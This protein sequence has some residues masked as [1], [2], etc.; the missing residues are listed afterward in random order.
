M[1]DAAIKALL[2]EE[3]VRLRKAEGAEMSK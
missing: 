1:A 3:D 2:T